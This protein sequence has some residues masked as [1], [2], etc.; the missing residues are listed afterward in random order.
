MPGWIGRAVIGLGGGLWIALG[1]AGATGASAQQPAPPANPLDRTQQV[2]AWTVSDIGGKPGDDSEREV[3]VAR[4]LEGL[5]FVLHR[6]SD[7]GA[8]VTIRFTRCAGL[9]WNSGF[10]LEGEAPARAAQVKDE[11]RDAFKDFAKSCPV[12]AGEEAALLE[13]FDAADAL[14]E[15]WIHARPFSAPPDTP[16][17]R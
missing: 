1:L 4:S 9:N 8:E 12:K 3:R 11:I 2:G 10:S 14:A 5:A 7:D 16:T 6:S 17:P 13:G 15:S